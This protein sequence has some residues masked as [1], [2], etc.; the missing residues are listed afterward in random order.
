MIIT[1]DKI[2]KFSEITEVKLLNEVH[3]FK[4]CTLHTLIKH[5]H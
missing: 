1:V 4:L 5:D 3:N 2:G